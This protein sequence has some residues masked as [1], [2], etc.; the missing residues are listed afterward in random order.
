MPARAGDPD[1]QIREPRGRPLIADFMRFVVLPF[2]AALLWG[3]GTLPASSD[4]ASDAPEPNARAAVRSLPMPASYAEALA[5][6]HAPRD[7]NAWIGAKFE[8]DTDRAV[9]LSESQRRAGPA[10]RIVEPAAFYDRPAGVCVDLARF[11][12]ETLKQ[13]SPEVEARYLM[14]EFDPATLRGQVLR[15]HWVV[16]YDSPEGLR[17]FADSK[18]PGVIAGPYRTVDE[19]IAEYAR[20]RQRQVVSYRELDSYQRRQRTQAKRTKSDA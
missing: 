13:V 18:R 8:Y 17:V 6:W 3:C 14:I 19:F 5:A 7:V 20:F 11:A 2:A 10:P 12:V 4:A 16:V 1:R 15:R 9:A